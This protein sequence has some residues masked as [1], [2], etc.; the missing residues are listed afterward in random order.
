DK[1]VFTGRVSFAEVVPYLAGMDICTAPDPSNGYNDRSTLIKVMEYMAQGKPTV[2]FDLTETRYSAGESG[3]YVRPNDEAAFAQALADLMDDP[4]R[5][6]RL[7][8]AGLKRV[9]ESLTW[10]HS[11]SQLVSAYQALTGKPGQPS[12]APPKTPDTAISSNSQTATPLEQPERHE[13]C[14]S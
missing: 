12:A 1:L 7:G 2:A 8:A 13:H 9:S 5:R 4:A 6:E 3:V 14:H 11:A 10:R